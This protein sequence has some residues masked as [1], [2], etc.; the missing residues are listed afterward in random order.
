LPSRPPEPTSQVQQAIAVAKDASRAR[1]ARFQIKA[2]IEKKDDETIVT[3]APPHSDLAGWQA[4]WLETFGTSSTDF[5]NAE[6]S[7]SAEA[8]R[9]NGTV[10]EQ[11]INAV[12]AVV[13]GQK[14]KDEVEALLLLQMAVTH[15]LMMRKAGDLGRSETIPQQD[16]NGIAFARLSK[17][18]TSQLEALAK[19]RRGGEQKVT[20]EHVHV[21][22]GGQ[23][24]VGHVTHSGGGATNENN[25]Q[26]HANGVAALAVEGSAPMRGK[27]A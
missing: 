3:I 14:P 21:H 2:T 19:L 26:P 10:S 24:V 4:H 1:S 8:L 12:L 25:G 9:I 16:S 20:V 23:A 6:L 17:A 7:R 27:D 15:A 5:V 13:S 11:N 22:S 18:F